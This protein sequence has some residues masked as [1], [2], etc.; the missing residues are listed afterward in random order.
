MEATS[1]SRSADGSRFS[2]RCQFGY[3]LGCEEVGDEKDGVVD[4]EKKKCK[5][6][7][8]GVVSIT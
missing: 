4:M 6:D 5:V 7:D 2:R 1:A 3:A 8:I